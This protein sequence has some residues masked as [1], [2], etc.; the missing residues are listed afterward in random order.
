MLRLLIFLL[1][2][3]FAAFAV[4]VLLTLGEAVKIE[5]FGW[6]MDVP[7]GVAG[8]ALALLLAATALVVSLWNGWSA[9]RRRSLLRAVLK[10]R[11]KGVAA[12]VEA[13]LAHQAADYRKSE[14]LAGKAAKLLD[15]DAIA[16]LFAAPAP[17]EIELDP[18][19]PEAG[20]EPP[21]EEDETVLAPPVEEVSAP[22]LIERSTEPDAP[23]PPDAGAIAPEQA[24]A[25]DARDRTVAAARQIS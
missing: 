15:R 8:A 18:P 21:D 23:A 5:A 12:L 13:A 14:R 11:E 16:T 20:T 2:V 17:V 4:T 25:E 7:A 10:R 9:L 24:D 1:W 6:R 19:P 22:P 3:V